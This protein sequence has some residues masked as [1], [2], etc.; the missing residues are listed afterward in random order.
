[1]KDTLN[2]KVK[3][4]EPFRPFAPSVLAE[5]ANAWFEVP[6]GALGTEYMLVACKVR[7]GRAARI[8]AVVHIDGTC[9]VQT[10]TREQNPQFH[11]V[12]SEFQKLTDVPVV[13]NTSL[14]DEEPIAC[15]PEDAITTFKKTAIDFLAVGPYL[16]GR[17]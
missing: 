8:P 2:R 4:R 16:V 17:P 9:R 1:M 15:T 6:E 12:I 11:A 5:E 13:L 14:N 10:V 7:E 3:H